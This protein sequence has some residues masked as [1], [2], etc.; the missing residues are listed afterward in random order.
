MF[1]EKYCQVFF[2]CPSSPTTCFDQDGKT[3]GFLGGGEMSWRFEGFSVVLVVYLTLLCSSKLYLLSSSLNRENAL[4]SAK[5]SL[6]TKLKNLPPRKNHTLVRTDVTNSGEKS[7]QT[8]LRLTLYFNQ[9]CTKK[10][11]ESKKQL[12]KSIVKFSNM[13]LISCEFSTS[14]VSVLV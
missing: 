10:S 13:K 12:L 3:Q 2:S 5:F 9:C 1:K 14:N 6:Q 4:G 11:T 8:D 7:N